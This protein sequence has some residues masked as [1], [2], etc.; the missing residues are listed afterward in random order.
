MAQR[1][2]AIEGFLK[3]TSVNPLIV[4]SASTKF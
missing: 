3:I 2:V 4:Q 1:A